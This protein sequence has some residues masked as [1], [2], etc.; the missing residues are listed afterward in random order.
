MD[1]CC[2]SY[3][4]VI[5]ECCPCCVSDWWVLSLLCECCV[6]VMWMLC[7]CC[8]SVVWPLC[9]CCA[10]V[11]W[12]LCECCVSVVQCCVSVVWEMCERCASVVRVMCEFYVSVVSLL[13][14]CGREERAITSDKKL[15]S[16]VQQFLILYFSE[17]ATIFLRDDVTRDN[18]LQIATMQ[19]VKTFWPRHYPNFVSAHYERV[20]V[21]EGGE[22][23]T[24]RKCVKWRK[25]I[26]SVFKKLFW[27][28]FWF[29]IQILYRTDDLS[30]K[31]FY[32]KIIHT[33]NVV[34]KFCPI[35]AERRVEEDTC[36][37]SL[38]KLNIIL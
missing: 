9:E 17:L 36:L 21:F 22:G 15:S 25:A 23:E 5:G 10:S 7:E 26:K 33:H 1:E 31:I 12:V 4:W 32:P 34:F 35:S 24:V 3:V 19:H 18:F 2:V 38:P 28:Q 11:V 8:L 37:L 29:F 6:N 16:S 30:F 13:C 27:I 14:G 20:T